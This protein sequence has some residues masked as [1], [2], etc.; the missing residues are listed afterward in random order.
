MIYKKLRQ[1]GS[2]TDFPACIPATSTGQ[3]Y[4]DQTG[5]FLSATSS[6]ATQL[7]VLY[8][9]N[10]DSIHAVPIS[11][12]NGP[13]IIKAFKSIHNT[14]V[15]AGLRPQLRRLDNEV[16]HELQQYTSD[17]DITMQ[18]VPP[19]IHRANAAERAIRTLKNHLI[20]GICVIFRVARGN[21]TVVLT[22]N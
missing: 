5:K 12:R 3:I 16:S 2:T 18:L 19:G 8:D 21:H 17:Q 9:F 20:S 1:Q 22:N 14:I 6:A 15:K 4:I 11:T 10:S 7:F 13:D